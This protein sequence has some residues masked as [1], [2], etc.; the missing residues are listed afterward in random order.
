MLIRVK[1]NLEVVGLELVK[2]VLYTPGQSCE[3]LG[4]GLKVRDP[5]DIQPVYAKDH[6]M[7]KR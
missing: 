1:E 7:F 6:Q 2:A 5:G 3:V 4:E